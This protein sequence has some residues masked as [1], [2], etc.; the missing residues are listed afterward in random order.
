[1]IE[2]K[3]VL[4]KETLY[5]VANKFINQAE[6]NTNETKDLLKRCGLD[7]EWDWRTVFMQQNPNRYKFEN[8]EK[9]RQQVCIAYIIF[10]CN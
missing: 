1:L 5:A 3:I 4:A 2:P 10:L 6:E 8:D 7:P 9:V